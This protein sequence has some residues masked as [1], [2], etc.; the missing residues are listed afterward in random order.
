MVRD[1][2]EFWII[3]IQGMFFEC[4]IS[5]LLHL[6]TPRHNIGKQI[7]IFQKKNSRCLK[8]APGLLPGC[9]GQKCKKQ[10]KNIALKAL[11]NFGAPGLLPGWSGFLSS[12]S[13]II[14]SWQGF[15][16][17]GAWKQA[18]TENSQLGQKCRICTRNFILGW[19]FCWTIGVSS[20]RQRLMLSLAGR[21]SMIHMLWCKK[22]SYPALKCPSRIYVPIFTKP[23]SKLCQIL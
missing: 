21:W 4:Q 6:I 23:K 14:L 17:E 15:S 11:S 8:N 5:S 10:N 9:S 18:V 12:K 20:A 22:K 7:P 16:P 13:R 3:N 1:F 2:S 19:A